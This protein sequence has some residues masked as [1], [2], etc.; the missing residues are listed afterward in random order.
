MPRSRDELLDLLREKLDDLRISNQVFDHGRLAESK[1]IAQAIRVLLHHTSRSHALINQ[2]GLQDSLTWVDTAGVIDPTNLASTG[3]LTA[4]RTGGG[5]EAQYIAMLDDYPPFD[6][7][8]ASGTRIRKG[9]RIPFGEWWGNDVIKDADGRLFSR[10][11]L[12]LALSNKE[13]GAHVDPEPE[14]AYAALAAGSMGWRH[15]IGDDTEGELLKS[16]PVF[17]SVRQIG[18]EV[19]E[20]LRQQEHLLV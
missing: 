18:Y 7:L 8:T 4:M 12:V 20:S 14:A 1:R 10:R 13:G 11:Q 19:I 9:S 2:L 16:N 3:G 6:M 15:H 5:Q 17:P